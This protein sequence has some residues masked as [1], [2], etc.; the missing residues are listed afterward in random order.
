VA[1]AAGLEVAETEIEPEQGPDE[2]GVGEAPCPFDQPGKPVIGARGDLELEPDG[3]PGERRAVGGQRV[4]GP[5][6][7]GGQR[8]D[9]EDQLA[10]RR[11]VAP[12]VV[13]WSRLHDD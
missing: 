12:R 9:V 2:E 5:L 13:R 11:R 7:V 1:V 10:E 3:R 8:Q 6:R 4:A